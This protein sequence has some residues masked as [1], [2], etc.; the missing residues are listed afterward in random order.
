ML[1]ECGRSCNDADPHV[2]DRIIVLRIP[3]N[4][5]KLLDLSFV[6]GQL[7]IVIGGDQLKEW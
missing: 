1:F 3:M 2:K 6:I 7:S 4:C 5:T